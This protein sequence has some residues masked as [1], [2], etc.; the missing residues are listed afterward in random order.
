MITNCINRQTTK[1]YF[2][3]LIS[4]LNNSYKNKNVNLSTVSKFFININ[5]NNKYQYNNYARKPP[6]HT[7]PEEEL[8]NRAI[9]REKQYNKLLTL[10]GRNLKQQLRILKDNPIDMLKKVKE[11]PMSEFLEVKAIDIEPIDENQLE[12]ID[13]KE[14]KEK[15]REIKKI[16]NQV[17]SQMKPDETSF[18]NIYMIDCLSKM[19]FAIHEIK[20]EKLIG[21]DI[22]AVEMGK[23]GEISLVQISTPNG[24]IYI[25]DIIKMGGDVIPFKYGLKEILESVKILKVVHDCR[26]DSEIL[27]H[28]YQ[29]E[30]AYIYDVQI[31]HALV[32]KKVQGNVPIRRYGF[33]ELI[34]L[35]T[36]RKYSEVCVNIKYKVKKQF[37][38]DSGIWGSRPLSKDFIDYASLDAACLLPVYY[39]IKPKLQSNFDRRFLKAHF[40]EQLTY[41]KDSIRQLYPRNLI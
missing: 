40:G 29:V 37:E 18:D 41:F 9:R 13:K 28:R 7:T 39:Q 22:E 5:D 14:I 36:S 23:K 38:N 20:K 25:F 6:K 26:R 33:N 31:A 4:E 24:H 27:F 11:E 32:Q 8:S 2:N 3:I 16:K 1:K 10:P 12:S 15:E 30:L 19:N 35:Y 17:V 21:L 34:D